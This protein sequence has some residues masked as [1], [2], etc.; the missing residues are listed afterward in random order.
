M[1]RDTF[2]FDSYAAARQQFGVTQDTGVTRAAEES[3]RT[4]G[5]LNPIVDP[6]INPTRF[7]KIRLDPPTTRSGSLP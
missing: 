5:K 7:S 2:S 4:T 6:A 1:G 3:A